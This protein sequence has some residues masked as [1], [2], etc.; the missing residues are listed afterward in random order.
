MKALQFEVTVPCYIAGRALG[1]VHKPLY[2]S[3]LSCLR[4]LDVPEPALPRP[5]PVKIRTRS[6][7]IHGSNWGPLQ[8]HR[9]PYLFPLGSTRSVIGHENL[10]PILELGPEVGGWRVAERTVCDFG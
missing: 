5:D 4:Y 10:G 7:G 1:A 8:L 6:G 3:G 9:S 2:W